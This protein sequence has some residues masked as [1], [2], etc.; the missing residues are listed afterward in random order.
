M[1][2]VHNMPWKVL[3]NLG[4]QMVAVR[5]NPATR[6]LSTRVGPFVEARSDI[7]MSAEE[8]EAFA[9]DHMKDVTIT[10]QRGA[11]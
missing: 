6:K 2:P 4:H 8:Y 3:R 5:Y 7:D 9:L 11:K 1:N 10:H